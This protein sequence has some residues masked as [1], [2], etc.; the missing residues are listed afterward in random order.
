MRAAIK[1]DAQK[2]FCSANYIYFISLLD[3][4]L[5][6]NE[7]IHGQYQYPLEMTTKTYKNKN[8]VEAI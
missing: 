3:I 8:Y 2:H 7:R 4:L 6:P 1:N 5:L